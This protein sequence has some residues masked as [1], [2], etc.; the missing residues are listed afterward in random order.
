MGFQYVV[1]SGDCLSAI[2]QRFY[3]D[4]SR[5][6]VI[7]NVNRGVIGNNPNL[8]FPGQVFYIP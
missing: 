4:A 2:A 8:I 7:Y 1:Q 3:G 5:W 6:P